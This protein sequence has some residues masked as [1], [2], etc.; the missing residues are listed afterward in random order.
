ML[1]D[2]YW[3]KQRRNDEQSVLPYPPDSFE[4]ERVVL[5]CAHK[6]NYYNIEYVIY[7]L[8][9]FQNKTIPAMSARCFSS[10]SVFSPFL[11]VIDI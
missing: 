8:H 10:Y 7:T 1:T 11:F 2:T 9:F 3:P 6:L 5:P 4:R